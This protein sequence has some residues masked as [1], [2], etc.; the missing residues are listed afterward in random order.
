MDKAQRAKE[1]FAK[2]E[3]ASELAESAAKD[4]AAALSSIF[5]ECGAGPYRRKNGMLVTVRHARGQKNAEAPT[6]VLVERTDKII[7][8]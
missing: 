2:Y 8:V 1:L 4:A 6:F 5:N 3:T 7:A